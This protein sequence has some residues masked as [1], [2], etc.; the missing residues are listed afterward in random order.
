[1]ANERS[2]LIFFQVSKNP[3]KTVLIVG[4]GMNEITVSLLTDCIVQPQNH[5]KGSQENG[6]K[7]LPPKGFII[8]H[9]GRKKQVLILRKLKHIA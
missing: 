4:K 8:L 1:M 6:N 9:N 3:H 2:D 5:K 7:D